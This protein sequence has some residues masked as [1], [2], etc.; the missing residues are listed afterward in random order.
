MGSSGWEAVLRS[1]DAHLLLVQKWTHPCQPEL[2]LRFWPNV[3]Q[4]TLL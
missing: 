3:D 1:R 4:L 2:L